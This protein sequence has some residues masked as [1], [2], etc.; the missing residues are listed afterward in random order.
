[1]DGDTIEDSV[2]GIVGSELALHGVAK[3]D[4]LQ[5]AII[6]KVCCVI[7]DHKQL[8]YHLMLKAL[9]HHNPSCKTMTSC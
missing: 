3:I 5:T 1:M 2:S 9:W 7:D 4:D 6:N 8:E